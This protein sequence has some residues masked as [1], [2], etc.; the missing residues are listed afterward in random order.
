MAKRKHQITADVD[1]RH[2][3]S[4]PIRDMDRDGEIVFVVDI[5]GVNPRDLATIP[6]GS[7]PMHKAI[8]RLGLDSNRFK[9]SIWDIP[10]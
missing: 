2:M 9:A 4:M 5:Y 6:G 8:E 3:V 1:Y 7:R 10:V